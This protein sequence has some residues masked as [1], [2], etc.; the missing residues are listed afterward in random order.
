MHDLAP[1]LDCK[2]DSVRFSSK[3]K[4]I[5]FSHSCEC[6]VFCHL[7]KIGLL[8]LDLQLFVRLSLQAIITVAWSKS[9]SYFLLFLE[10]LA[11]HHDGGQL[12]IANL[13]ISTSHHDWSKFGIQPFLCSEFSVVTNFHAFQFVFQTLTPEVKHHLARKNVTPL[14]LTFN[15]ETFKAY[16]CGFPVLVWVARPIASLCCEASRVYPAL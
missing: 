10:K 5:R 1:K 8:C 15:I 16:L 4:R 9:I 2:K 11:S 12:S 7:L 6:C 14:I 13:L 3:N